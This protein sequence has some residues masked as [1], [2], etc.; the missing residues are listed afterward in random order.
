MDDSNAPHFSVAGVNSQYSGTQTNYGGQIS[1]NLSQQGYQYSSGF[2]THVQAE[3]DIIA[4]LLS[5]QPTYLKKFNKMSAANK[6]ASWNWCSFLFG[7][8]WFAYRKMYGIAAV[9]IGIS[10][11]PAL[12][13][14]LGTILNL[15]LSICSG[16]FG[17]YFYKQ[18]IDSELQVA[19]SMGQYNKAAYIAKKGGTSTVGLIIAIIASIVVNIIITSL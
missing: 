18:H 4:F 10:F 9:Y 12:I 6:K 11:L 15:A 14:T 16:I 17:N 5:N 7:G 19:K 13:P 8:N 1:C 3:P 2:N